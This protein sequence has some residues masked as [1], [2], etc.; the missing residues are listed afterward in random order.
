MILIVGLDAFAAD[1]D[2]IVNGKVGI[3][4]TS[5]ATKLHVVGSDGSVIGLI[6]GST[7]ALRLGAR[8]TRAQVEAV[9]STVN[10]C[11]PTPLVRRKHNAVL[12]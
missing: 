1:G 9:D 7:N 3:G 5:P 4:T 6:S 11:I 2:L 8:D 12:Y 10:D